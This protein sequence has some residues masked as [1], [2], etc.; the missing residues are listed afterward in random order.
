[1]GYNVQMELTQE[2]YTLIK[3]FLPVGRGNCKV[4]NLHALNVMLYM[5]ENGCKWRCLPKEFGNWNTL[6]VKITRWAKKGILEKIFETLRNNGICETMFLDSTIVK[7]H[8]DA[9]G[10]LKKRALKASEEVA[11]G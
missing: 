5:A 8:P 7:V 10:A 1:M 9:A 6:Y 3:P 11:A 2:Q 4:D